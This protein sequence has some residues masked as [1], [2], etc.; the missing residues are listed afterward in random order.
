MYVSIRGELFTTKVVLENRSY[1]FNVKENRAGDVFLQLVESKNQQSGG[2]GA[3]SERRSIVLFAD[4]MQQFFKGLDESIS[5]IEKDKKERRKQHAE[6]IIARNTAA[7]KQESTHGRDMPKN[8]AADDTHDKLPK[9]TGRVHI[10][11]KRT[12]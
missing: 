5:F 3:D 11:S 9:K 8:S 6:K 10:V 4:D 2:S 1:F 12:T 7:R